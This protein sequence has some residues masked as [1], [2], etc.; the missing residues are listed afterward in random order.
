MQLLQ[1]LN[2]LIGHKTG[3]CYCCTRLPWE[4]V[5]AESKT[6]LLM[7]KQSYVKGLHVPIYFY[8]KCRLGT[9]KDIIRDGQL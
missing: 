9:Q 2:F 3:L 1:C 5:F 8:H 6:H 7:N 4:K